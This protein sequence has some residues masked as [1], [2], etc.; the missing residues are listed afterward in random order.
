M[1]TTVLMSV[2]ALIVTLILSVTVNTGIMAAADAGSAPVSPALSIIAGETPLAKSG[3]VGNEILFS[4]SDFERL[5]NIS[6][7]TSI[8][9]VSVPAVADGELLIGS[10]TVRAGQSISRANLGMLSFAAADGCRQASFEFRVNDSAYNLRCQ[11]Y[12]LDSVNYSPTAGG[13]QVSV[14][15]Y[16]DVAAYGKLSA[17]DP[18]GDPLT[19]QIVTYPRHGLVALS[20]GGQYIY[21]PDADYTGQDSFEY[22]VY[23]KYGNYS[24]ASRVR[25]EVSTS[26]SSAQYEDMKSSKAYAAAIKLTDM[27]VMNGTQVGNAR[28]FYPERGVTRCEFVVMALKAAGI[29]SLPTISDTGFVDDSDISSALKPYI[30]TAARSGY[31]KGS[32]LD[33]KKYFFPDAPMTIA[34][35]A[36]VTAAMLEIDTDVAV[37]AFTGDDSAPVWARAAVGQLVSRGLLSDDNKVDY[38]AAITREQAAILLAGLA[39][40]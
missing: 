20:D 29:G 31:I 26:V 39:A 7:L 8:M 33:G 10:S 9:V 18:E 17:A 30:A 5:L 2:S 34:E 22:V 19:Y 35:A 25:L 24:A 28:Y 12:L 37:A 38:G 16:R 40:D 15:T 4:P 13:Q 1:K 14:S 36:T 27:G 6:P 11:M 32:S 21:T 3:I 23:D